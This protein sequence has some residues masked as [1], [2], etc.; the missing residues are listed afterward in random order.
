[1]DFQ[2]VFTFGI[3]THIESHHHSYQHV[4]ASK[5]DGNWYWKPVNLS[6]LS[7]CLSE[8]LDF[9]VVPSFPS[10]ITYFFL[11][12]NAPTTVPLFSAVFAIFCSRCF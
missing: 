3:L 2:L 8:G 1:M 7:P 6:L 10:S 5:Q 11:Q 12:A 4:I 9:G